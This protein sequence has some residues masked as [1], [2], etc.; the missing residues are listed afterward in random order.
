MSAGS[1]EAAGEIAFALGRLADYRGVEIEPAVV[2][3][4]DATTPGIAIGTPEENPL[5]ASLLGAQAPAPGE[6]LLALV[7]DPVH[8]ERAIL[9][10]TGSTA[11][12]TGSD[13]T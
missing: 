4:A 7:P 10:V 2:A 11:G 1:L 3:I 13:R 5:V 6:G 9:V 12:R 8:P